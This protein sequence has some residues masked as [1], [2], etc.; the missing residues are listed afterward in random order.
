MVE[1]QEFPTS[2]PDYT[3]SVVTERM[4]DGRWSAVATATQRIG[5][6]EHVTPV[7]TGNERFETEAVARERVLAAARDWI[8]RNAPSEA[9][10]PEPR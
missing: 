1:R 3:V 10:H 7:P 2:H 6:V 8:A 4:R 9:G 5:G